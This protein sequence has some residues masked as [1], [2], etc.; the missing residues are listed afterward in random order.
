FHVTGVQTCALPIF[1]DLPRLLRFGALRQEMLQND[2]A[3]ALGP[4]AQVTFQVGLEGRRH[5]GG[6]LDRLARKAQP[7]GSSHQGGLRPTLIVAIRIGRRVSRQVMQL[8]EGAHAS[9]F[10][11]SWAISG[12]WAPKY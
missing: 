10:S 11:L 7:L 2:L 8:Q 4:L 12:A 1:R 3:H 5:P 6:P 9:T